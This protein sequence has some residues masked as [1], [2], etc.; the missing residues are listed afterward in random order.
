LFFCY[1]RHIYETIYRIKSHTGKFNPKTINVF[2]SEKK[3]DKKNKTRLFH[4]KKKKGH[5]RK[6]GKPC[7]KGREKKA[8]KKARR[9]D[10]LQTFDQ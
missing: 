2:F 7:K 9:L 10:Y 1:T 3:I 4:V 8:R 5:D 6:T